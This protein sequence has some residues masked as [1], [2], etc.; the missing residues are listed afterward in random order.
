NQ[1]LETVGA[2]N[3]SICHFPSILKL[4]YDAMD[5]IEGL[6]LTLF[7]FLTMGALLLCMVRTKRPRP[8]NPQPKGPSEN[9]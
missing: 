6:L 8:D 4:P 7:T 9:Q 5:F 1:I 3:R 2:E